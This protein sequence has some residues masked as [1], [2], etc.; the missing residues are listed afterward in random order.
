MVCGTN[1]APLPPPLYWLAPGVNV[2]RALAANKLAAN[3]QDLVTDHLEYLS[4]LNKVR[5]RESAP[6]PI[7]GCCV[8][9]QSLRACPAPDVLGM[10]TILPL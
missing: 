5:R 8:A 2:L 10:R 9:A 4:D 1:R 6:G 3:V 7:F